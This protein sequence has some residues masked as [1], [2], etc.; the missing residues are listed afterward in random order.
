VGKSFAERKPRALAPG[1]DKTVTSLKTIVSGVR[2]MKKKKLRIRKG[3]EDGRRGGKIK[4]SGFSKG[5]TWT[6]GQKPLFPTSNKTA[7]VPKVG[8]KTSTFRPRKILGNR[9]GNAKA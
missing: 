7:C 1:H 3:E 8:K 2:T 4:N 5:G 9:G 6:G